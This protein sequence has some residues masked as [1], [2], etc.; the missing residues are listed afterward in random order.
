MF[1]TMKAYKELVLETDILRDAFRNSM[2]QQTQKKLLPR[3]FYIIKAR[4]GV[5]KK[6]INLFLHKVIFIHSRNKFCPHERKRHNRK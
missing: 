6:Y 5:T 3:Q 2:L 4:K 1:N